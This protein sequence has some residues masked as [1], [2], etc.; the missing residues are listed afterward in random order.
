MRLLSRLSQ[1]VAALS[2]SRE[3]IDAD[4]EARTAARRGTTPVGQVVPRTRT[5]VSGVLR[6]VT[7]GPATAKPVLTGQLYDGTG[8]IDLVWIGRRSIAGIRP[9]VHLRAEGVV[10]AGRTRP[11]IYNPAYE[12]L[13]EDR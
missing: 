6:A 1:A 11:T 4:D 8:S 12:L 3:Q 9:G 13:G 10:A 2:P 7:Y 5:T